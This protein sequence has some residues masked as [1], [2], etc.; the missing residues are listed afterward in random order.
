M[1]IV[2]RWPIYRPEHPGR[3]LGR[4]ERS[5]VMLNTNAANPL[6]LATLDFLF[7]F[8]SPFALFSE[9]PDV[10]RY[11]RSRIVVVVVVASASRQRLSPSFL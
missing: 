4:G 3:G 8:F 7:Y 9:L 6:N 10:W 11:A 1:E 5:P 2:A